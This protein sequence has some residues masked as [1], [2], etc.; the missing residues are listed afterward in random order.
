[1]TLPPARGDQVRRF[2]T[3][4]LSRLLSSLDG[5]FYVFCCINARPLWLYVGV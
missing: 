1:M 4:Y 2:Q 3:H 5:K